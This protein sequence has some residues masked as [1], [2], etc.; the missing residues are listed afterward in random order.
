MN[1]I[2]ERL[3][4]RSMNLQLRPSPTITSLESKMIYRNSKYILKQ[5]K[6]TNCKFIEYITSLE[7]KLK[8]DQ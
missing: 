7:S 4:N 1:L 5:N 6:P 2:N 8:P 3:N